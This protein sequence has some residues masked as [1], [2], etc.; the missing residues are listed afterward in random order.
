MYAAFIGFLL[1]YFIGLAISVVLKLLKVQGKSLIYT[2][3][4]ETTINPDLFLPPK[5]RLIRKRNKKFE[6]TTRQNEE[7][8]EKY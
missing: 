5:A 4:S 8:K 2:D 1:S 6:E 7:M 3:D